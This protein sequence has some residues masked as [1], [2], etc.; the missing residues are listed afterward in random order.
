MSIVLYRRQ[1]GDGSGCLY[2]LDNVTHEM[3]LTKSI[4]ELEFEYY[5]MCN[6]RYD[7]LIKKDKTEADVILAL[8]L[9]ESRIALVSQRCTTVYAHHMSCI[10]H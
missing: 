8:K 7:I 3:L 5:Q 2:Q 9:L 4:N 6:R 10:C 1:N